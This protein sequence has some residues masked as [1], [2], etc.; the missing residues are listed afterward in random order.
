MPSTPATPSTQSSPAIVE[1]ERIG[2]RYTQEAQFDL[3]RLSADHRVQVREDGHYAPKENVERYAIQMELAAFPPIVVTS[4]DYLVDGNTRVA[5][6]RLRKDG[7]FP[8]IVLDTP[9]A[10]APP[11]RQAELRA[12]AATLNAMAGQ[13]LT[14]QETRAAVEY[15]LE[16]NWTAQQIGRAIGIKSSRINQIKRE[17]DA[18]EKLAHVG[19][20]AN[21]DLQGTSLRALGSTSAL[22]LHDEP[23]KKLATLAI[24]A[25]LN[26]GEITAAAKEM[27]A[28][29]SD[30]A[31][32]VK[33]EALRTENE[34]RIR[35]RA[36]TGTGKPPLARM[37]RQHIGFIT[38]FAGEEE[39]FVESNAAVAA[40]HVTALEDA[41]KV[42]AATLIKQ[43]ALS[44]PAV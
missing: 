15:F 40:Q 7:R 26:A 27:E 24:D 17:I 5:A 1:I 6:A 19:I 4:D 28:T 31:G 34:E 30:L 20:S 35:Q 3:A 39:K 16:L 29:G 2:L 23:Y 42:L 41:I 8:A 12:L 43:H 9:F 11:A 37:L 36:L 13:G 38:K 25:G 10:T 21:G 32:I 33:I 14:R 44:A 22:I 18:R